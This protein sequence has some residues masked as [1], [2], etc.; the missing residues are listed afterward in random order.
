MSILLVYMLLNS[1]QDL[2]RHGRAEPLRRYHLVRSFSP[3]RSMKSAT[4]EHD[5]DAAAALV[6]SLGLVPSVNAGDSFVMGEPYA[7]PPLSSMS[8]RSDH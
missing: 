3:P 8:I 6:G 5:R 7:T 2:R 4:H 1:P